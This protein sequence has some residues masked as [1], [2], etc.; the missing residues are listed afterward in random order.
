M[1]L[2]HVPSFCPC[3][4]EACEHQAF[5]EEEMQTA[6]PLMLAHGLLP[7]QASCSSITAPGRASLGPVWT[8]L[9]VW[10]NGW[11]MHPWPL[12]CWSSTAA[13]LCSPCSSWC[14]RCCWVLPGWPAFRASSVT[15]KCLHWAVLFV[16]K[17]TKKNAK[18]KTGQLLRFLDI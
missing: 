13:K 3:H 16:F 6:G 11:G 9:A 2:T 17:V 4:M 7:A 8:A 1:S 14:A 15:I 18:G 12:P 5:R 10:G